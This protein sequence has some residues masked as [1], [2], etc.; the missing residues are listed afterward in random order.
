M[1]DLKQTALHG[2]HLNLKAKM[3]GFAG[4]DMPLYYAEG[5]LAEHDWVRKSA[6]LFDVS[7]MGQAMIK[8]EQATQIVETLTPSAFQSHP[9]D[10]A[11][12]TVLLNE[13]GGIIDDVMITKTGDDWY[14]F[15]LNAGRKNI[16]IEWIMSHLP[17]GIEFKHY[18]DWALLA[19]QGPKSEQIIR[20]ALEIDLSDLGYMRLW[21]QQDFSMFISRLGYT[22]ED[23]FEISIPN[24]DA[25]AL[26][27]KLLQHDDVKPAGL[28][29]RDG[30]RLEMGYPLYGHDIDEQTSPV[31][32][33]LAWV[34]RR[35][36]NDFKGGHIVSQQQANGVSKIRVG[37]R[38]IDKGVAREGAVIC[39]A[40]DNEIGALTSG[41]YSPI[42]QQSIGMGYVP[43]HF[44]TPGTN[45]FIDV[46]GRKIKA[47]ICSCQFLKPR[48][49]SSKSLKKAS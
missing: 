25:P 31:E 39:D 7:H 33:D 40:D 44:Q 43:I 35:T 14:H 34:I 37:I 6:G 12:Y 11:K 48:T 13:N 27:K 10:K 26:W 17:N 41:G 20:E 47:E 22:G 32:A 19:L 5:V 1:T 21:S 9:I 45:V 49:K 15:V 28:A 46:R 38:L 4:Y 8:G 42:L 16:D 30:L 2:E 36:D 18:D 3:A 23:G 24:A 29:T